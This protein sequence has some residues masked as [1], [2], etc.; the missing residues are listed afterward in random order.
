MDNYTIPYLGKKYPPFLLSSNIDTVDNYYYGEGNYT[1]NFDTNF[2]KNTS[3]NTIEYTNEPPIKIISGNLDKINFNSSDVNHFI[4]DFNNNGSGQ[5]EY[6]INFP[7]NTECDI[8][9][10]GG[11]GGG[12]QYNGAGGGGGGVIFIA[13]H[14]L[15]SG[16]YIVNVGDGATGGPRN[17]GSKRGY[18]SSLTSIDDSSMKWI[19]IGGGNGG[20]LTT[21]VHPV[22]PVEVVLD[23][24]HMVDYQTI[25]FQM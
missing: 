16:S 10:V 22:V 2:T 17:P 6:T 5:T 7:E 23:I 1:I 21:L 8:L 18:N 13:K 20:G 11:G 3:V 25:I 15:P 9:I 19:A 12:G 24:Q 14:I 4:V